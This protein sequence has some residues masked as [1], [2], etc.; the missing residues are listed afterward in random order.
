[1]RRSGF[2]AIGLALAATA[3]VPAER[4]KDSDDARHFDLRR[5]VPADSAVVESPA[6]VR[7]W[8]TEVPQPNSTAVRLLNGA[9]DPVETDELKQDREDGRVFAMP[10]GRPLPPGPYTVAWRG[11]GSDGHVVRGDFTFTVVTP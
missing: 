3:A 4:W 5:S 1:M 8:F 11:I 10:I 6:E 2:L 7:L 9:E